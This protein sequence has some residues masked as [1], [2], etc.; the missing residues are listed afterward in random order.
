[1]VKSSTALVP[2]VGVLIALIAFS[3]E[4]MASIEVQV[5]PFDGTCCGCPE[6]TNLYVDLH[7]DS[8]VD[9]DVAGERSTVDAPGLLAAVRVALARN[10][11]AIYLNPDETVSWGQVVET[12]S[13]LEHVSA[14]PVALVK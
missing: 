11:D 2:L 10:I 3:V 4:Q 5:P 8:S 13:S 6:P 7:A 1:M 9:L 14:L 12:A